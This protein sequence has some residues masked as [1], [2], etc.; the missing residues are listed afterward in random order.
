MIQTVN[1]AGTLPPS[2]EI[3]MAPVVSLTVNVKSSLSYLKRL[4]IGRNYENDLRES[5]AEELQLSNPLLHVYSDP[6]SIVT[7]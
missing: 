5:T 2:D 7:L 1:L 6:A 4:D 3:Q